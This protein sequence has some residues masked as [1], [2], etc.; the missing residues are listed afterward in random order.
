MFCKSALYAVLVYPAKLDYLYLPGQYIGI[1][2]GIDLSAAAVTLP[3][4]ENVGI[5]VKYLRRIVVYL[6]LR[7]RDRHIDVDVRITVVQGFYLHSDG[8]KRV[9]MCLLVI[10]TTHLGKRI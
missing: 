3:E 1:F 10:G 9:H 8:F 6:Y 7:A 4:S 2:H 5:D